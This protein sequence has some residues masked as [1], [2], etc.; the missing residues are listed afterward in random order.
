[1]KPWPWYST[2]QDSSRHGGRAYRRSSR[3]EAN[4]NKIPSF[5]EDQGGLSVVMI[6]N[7]VKE[8]SNHVK[9][10]RTD[11]LDDSILRII[12]D[13]PSISAVTLA[14]TLGVTERTIRF[15]LSHLR[16]QGIIDRTGSDTPVIGLLLNIDSSRF[17]LKFTLKFTLQ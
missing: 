13:N 8:P 6:P 9:E 14:N 2:L 17:T 10:G 1:M 15:H 16:K 4:G 5:S 7:L 12:L 3:L 11:S